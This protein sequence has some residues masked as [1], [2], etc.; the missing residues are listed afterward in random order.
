MSPSAEEHER[1]SL[2]PASEH[3]NILEMPPRAVSS[4]DRA[5]SIPFQQSTGGHSHAASGEGLASN[6]CSA[7]GEPLSV[8]PTGLVRSPPED[9]VDA[10]NG[11]TGD[12]AQT[13]E[14]FGN[15][16]AGSFMRQIQAAINARLRA[17]RSTTPEATTVARGCSPDDQ[18]SY[19]SYEETAL[20]LLPPRGFADSL[21]QAYWEYDWILY[22]ILDRRSVEAIYASLWMARDMGTYSLIHLSIINLCFALGCHYTKMLPPKDRV[23]SGDSF[24]TRAESLYKKAKDIPSYERVQ[25]L[26]LSGIYLQSTSKV[27]QCWMTV[28]HAIRMA[29][30]LGIHTAAPASSLCTGSVSQREYKRRTWHGCVWLDR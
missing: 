12:P 18:L 28:G 21:M 15:S 27:F 23:L 8:N 29:Q 14:V 6:D 24:F 25:Y 19:S 10:M 11:V 2:A 9:N 16:S 5:L 7:P 30:S 26:L 1:P 17:P 22:P 4:D 13:R 3:R 20:F